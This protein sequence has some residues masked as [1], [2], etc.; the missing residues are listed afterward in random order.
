MIRI[1]L[2]TVLLV[3]F[4]TKPI[5]GQITIGALKDPESFS[6][7]ELAGDNTGGLRLPQ[8]ATSAQRDAI[9]ASFK[10]NL[11]YGLLIFNMETDCM[12]YWSG[13]DWESLCSGVAHI[14]LT[15]ETSCTYDPTELVPADG[16]LPDRVYTPQDNP[17]CVVPSGQAYQVFLMAGTAYATLEV[18]EI[19]SAFSIT[20]SP[21]NSSRNRIAVVRVVN[22][23]SGEHQDFVFTQAGATCPSNATDF[24]LQSNTTE[25]CGSSGAAV[26]WVVNPQPGTDY[27]WEYGGVLVNTG[28]YMEIIRPGKYTVYA[29]LL[30][31]TVATPQ[32]ITITQNSNPSY[33]A[34]VATAT[35]SGILCSG[36]S[37]I[38][39]ANNVTVPVNWYHNG[40]LYTGTQANPLTVS[41]PSAAGE[42][43]AV[44]ENG[45]CGSRISNKITLIDETGNSTA[46]QAP[47]ATVNGTPL[48]GGGNIT[49]CKSGTLALEVT[50]AGAYPAGSIY[51]WFDNGVSISRG[52]APVIYTVA[53]DKTSMTL[54]VQVSNNTGDCP[55]SAMS[56]P[57]DISFTAPAPT[58]INNGARTAAVCGNTAATL[59]ALNSSGASYEW[60]KDGVL[61]SSGNSSSYLAAQPGSYT[62]RFK[63]GNGC[64]SPLSTGITVIQSAAISLKWQVEPADTVSVH[65][66]KSYTVFSSPA[67]DK[68]TWTSSDSTVATV[69]PIDGGKTVSVN[70]LIPDTTVIISVTAENNCGPIHLQ[71]EI[72]IDAGCTPITSVTIAPSGTITKALDASGNP[73]SSGDDHTTFT[74][75]ATDGT[76]AAGGYEWYVDNVKQ[77]ESSSTFTYT[78][79]PGS[80]SA[81]TIYAAALNTCT[82]SNTAKSP[83]VTVNVTKDNPADVSGS[84]RLTGK[85][86]FDVARSN[87][88]PTCMPLASRTDD[89]ASTK[90]FSYTFSNTTTFS[91]LTFEVA[92]NNSLIVS[93]STSGNTFTVTFRDDINAVAAGRTK[94]NALQ[95]TVTAKF[96]DNTSA[97]K[98]IALDVF[99]QDCSCGCTV[100]SSLPAGLL[101]F[102]CYNLGV[103]EKTKQMSIAE[104]MATVSPTGATT[105]SIIYG[106]LY[107]W[108][109]KADGH[110]LRTS[111]VVTTQIQQS[112]LDAN[113]QVALATAIG[114]FVGASGDWR[115]PSNNLLWYN[116]GKTVNDPCPP[117]WRIP[118]QAEWNSIYGTVNKWT[119]NSSGTAGYKVSPDN[120]TTY[121][122]FLPAGGMR[123]MA[124][125]TFYNAGT[126]GQYWSSTPG[127]T[128]NSPTTA[129][130][131]LFT[132]TSVTPNSELSRGYGYSI[133]C[134][135]DK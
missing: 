3:F 97:P 111:P 129:M 78:T 49:A 51:E 79:P 123:H 62:V 88:D 122:L 6:V 72:A 43:F 36:G 57:I 118:S 126:Q 2:T 99:V 41:G 53:P 38:L 127:V 108:G 33:G 75:T 107:Q 34:P 59:Q 5:I 76:P 39:T 64:W 84:Y 27:L 85:T 110:Q 131:M 28:N 24:S 15:C 105:D 113:G 91:N 93:T 45:T 35:N 87:D 95:F 70:Y 101:T 8:I 130:Y 56:S 83:S 68:Y 67:P 77:S 73:K 54:S 42:W 31:C 102:L 134:V 1:F 71:K 94:L 66:Q 90:S 119:W 13:K 22:N 44:Q 132:S 40:A 86:C 124:G 19:T 46:L 58:T 133:R 60:L 125:G 74:A 30:G 109:R 98:Q 23:C 121:T 4:A 65:T 12:E 114:K 96:T 50:N 135:Q 120:G 18:D 81:H 9:E 7:L 128:V 21:N 48:S 25:I 32:V 80:A 20:F 69:T 14:T 55:S 115:N 61:I 52:T 112:Q 82:P 17:A 100:K 106:A 89:F 116:N 103:P 11:A 92:D 117:G 29:G 104:Q 10:D 47:K 37:V 26:V 63:D 16:I